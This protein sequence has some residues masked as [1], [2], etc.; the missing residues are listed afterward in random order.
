MQRQIGNEES[1]T[2]RSNIEAVFQVRLPN[3][4]QASTSSSS[5]KDKPPTKLKPSNVR[6]RPIPG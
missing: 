1:R 2:Q 3:T 6:R 5:G 4:G